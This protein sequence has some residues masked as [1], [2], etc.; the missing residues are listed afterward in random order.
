MFWTPYKRE[1]TRRHLPGMKVRFA[2]FKDA[3]RLIGKTNT[4]HGR[5]YTTEGSTENRK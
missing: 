2:F 5:A 3:D 4:D 1:W